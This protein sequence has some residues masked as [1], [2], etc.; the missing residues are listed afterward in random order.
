MKIEGRT[1]S[2]SGA[3]FVEQISSIMCMGTFEC[4]ALYFFHLDHQ[5]GLRISC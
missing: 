3:A 5:F 4:E 2:V 1:S